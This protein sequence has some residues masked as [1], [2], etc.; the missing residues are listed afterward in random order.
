MHKDI[1]INGD[2]ERLELL[3]HERSLVIIKPDGVIRHLVGEI[4]S[5]FESKGLKIVAM[6]MIHPTKELVENHYMADEDWYMSTGT[7]TLAGYETQG[8]DAGMTAREIGLNTRRKLMEYLGAGPV[9]VM[10]LE[11]AHVI[12]S[13]RKMRG[14]TSPLG[15]E[16]GSIGFDYTLES[17]NLADAG[18]WAI[19]NIIHGSDAP[20][21]A[22]REIKLWFKD[23]EIVEYSTA[24]EHIIYGTEW[25]QKP[26]ES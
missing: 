19:R 6:K 5:R 14:A 18:G 11:G 17:Y 16:V 13:V 20:E 7:R 12:E 24:L 1:I 8:I 10:V 3:R 22:Q 2:K 9:V 4:I 21:A 26:R 23:D 25:H 15:A